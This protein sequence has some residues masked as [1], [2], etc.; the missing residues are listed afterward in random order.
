MELWVRL[1]LLDDSLACLYSLLGNPSTLKLA[2]ALKNWR[3]QISVQS[4]SNLASNI[5]KLLMLPN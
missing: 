4:A 2:L 5:S 3:C 1:W